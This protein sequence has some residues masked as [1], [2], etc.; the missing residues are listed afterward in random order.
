MPGRMLVIAGSPHQTQEKESN[1]IF[2]QK[3]N[4]LLLNKLHIVTYSKASLLPYNNHYKKPF[5]LKDRRSFL[6]STKV[7]GQ[8]CPTYP[9]TMIAG[10]RTKAIM[11]GVFN[12]GMIAGTY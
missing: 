2:H 9:D 6:I 3:Q 11:R 7:A 5:L 10:I 12:P 4:P 8:E 1:P